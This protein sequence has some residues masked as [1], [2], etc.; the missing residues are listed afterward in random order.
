[1]IILN[2]SDSAIHSS[3]PVRNDSPIHQPIFTVVD[4]ISSWNDFARS[5]DAGDEIKPIMNIRAVVTSRSD[6]VDPTVNLRAVVCHS[7][8]KV[9]TVNIVNKKEQA[10]KMNDDHETMYIYPY[11]ASMIVP[12]PFET[13]KIELSASKEEIGK[14]AEAMGTEE[15]DDAHRKALSIYYHPP[16]NKARRQRRMM[17]LDKGTEEQRHLRKVVEKV[18]TLYKTEYFHIGLRTRADFNEDEFITVKNRWGSQL[19]YEA[20]EMFWNG[21]GDCKT[22]LHKAEK[23]IEEL[24]SELARAKSENKQQVCI[25]W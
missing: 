13:L 2:T 4:H 24:Q 25:F 14:A 20:E 8:F 12:C 17:E 15:A 19:R 3:P 18:I 5:I 21:F 1:M 16:C 7:S 6:I 23:R 11:K 22:K 9:S 10:N